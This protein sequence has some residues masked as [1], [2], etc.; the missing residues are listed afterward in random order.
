MDRLSRASKSNISGGGAG[1]VEVGAG[2]EREDPDCGWDVFPS[3][4]AGL[5]QMDPAALVG[6][7]GLGAITPN[8]GVGGL[9]IVGVDFAP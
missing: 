2:V 4:N 7:A 6:L 8:D 9:G 3:K 5:S 1:D